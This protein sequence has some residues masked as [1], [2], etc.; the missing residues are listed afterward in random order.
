MSLRFTL[1]QLEYF[2]AVGEAGS[3]VLASERVNVSSPSISSA[4]SHLENEFGIALFVRK[5]AHG[6]HLTQAGQL[7]LAKA[8]KVLAEADALN[9]LA[10]DI[11]GKVQGPLKIGCLL[12][13][14]QMLL[15]AIRREFERLYPEAQVSQLEADQTDLLHFRSIRMAK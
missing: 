8:K 9:R 1:R 5:H 2:V 6:L 4:I 14:A 15:P 13:F 3:I 10:D 7:F 11:T 12:T